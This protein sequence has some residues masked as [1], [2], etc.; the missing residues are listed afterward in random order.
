MK[1]EEYNSHSQEAV[2][3]FIFHFSF[4]IFHSSFNLIF[5]S[6]YFLLGDTLSKLCT[7]T[8]YLNN[9]LLLEHCFN[10]RMAELDCNSLIIKVNYKA[11]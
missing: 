11:L 8:I 4:F 6:S 3:F 1:N 5:H 2:P 7:G 9:T 10:H